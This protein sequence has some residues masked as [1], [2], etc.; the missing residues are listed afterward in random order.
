M[1]T[2]D[3]AFRRKQ[4]VVVA[5]GIAAAI[6]VA[7]VGAHAR[8]WFAGWAPAADDLA[9]RLAFAVRWLLA[10]GVM[11]LAGIHVAASRGFHSDAIDGTRTPTSHYLE[12]ALRY[13][14]NTL[15]QTVLAAI[16]WCGLALAVPHASLAFIPAMAGLFVVGRVTF[17]LG[18]LVYPTARAFGMVLTALPTIAAY[19]WLVAHWLGRRAG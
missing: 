15:E 12:I 3:P 1:A 8:D 17:W 9:T 11:L 16:A 2:R 4:G 7:V 19:V 6:V 14:Q 13:N 18:Y 5:L 10:P